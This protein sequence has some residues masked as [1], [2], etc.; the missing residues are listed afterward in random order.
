MPAAHDIYFRQLALLHRGYPLYY[1]DPPV[2]D[3]PV[4]IGD[5]GFIRG[6]SFIR[7]FNASKPP[8]DPVQRYGV[9]E[10]F[11][12][13]ELGTITIYDN[14]LEVGPLHYASFRFNCTSK[15]GAVLMLETQMKRETA[16]QGQ[17]FESYLRRHYRSW[18]EFAQRNYFPLAFG[19]ML[20]V[21]ECSKTAGWSSSVYWSNSGAFSLSFSPSNTSTGGFSVVAGSR[22]TGP[23]EHRRSTKR[24][25][26]PSLKNQTVFIKAYHLGW[27]QLYYLSLARIFLRNR[28]SGFNKLTSQR[29]E[30]P[31]TSNISELSN[32]MQSL[33][34]LTDNDRSIV[35]PSKELAMQPDLP[36][37]QPSFVLLGLELETSDTDCAILHDDIWCSPTPDASQTIDDFIEFYFNILRR[38]D[39]YHPSHQLGSYHEN[40]GFDIP[41]SPLQLDLG[42]PLVPRRRAVAQSSPTIETLYEAPHTGMESTSALGPLNPVAQLFTP[43]VE[44]NPDTRDSSDKTDSSATLP[45][46]TASEKRQLQGGQYDAKRVYQCF[47]PGCNK[48]YETLNHLNAHIT[49]QNHGPELQPSDFKGIGKQWYR[50]KKS[51]SPE[52]ERQGSPPVRLYQCSQ[53]GCNRSYSNLNQLNRHIAMHTTTMPKHSPERHQSEGEELHNRWRKELKSVSPELERQNYRKW[54]RRFKSQSESPQESLEVISDEIKNEAK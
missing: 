36:D 35:N 52:P 5:V 37:F 29:L 53:P 12:R 9:P 38:D 3:S 51:V 16:I 41:T 23:L 34:P 8:N 27:R 31:S 7:L 22:T 4:E 39:G 18:H 24:P 17:R 50:V 33:G 15:Q 1:P 43:K 54:Y 20:L 42:S 30:E 6:G 45:G 25:C 44:I 21:T 40:D 19:D 48:W 47:W 49:M 13:L 28:D 26:D 2:G 11:E 10:G 46:S 14:A 32:Q